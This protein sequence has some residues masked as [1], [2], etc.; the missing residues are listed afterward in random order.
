MLG[1]TLNNLGE[2]LGEGAPE[3]ERAAMTK[4][5]QGKIGG[6]PFLPH[7]NIKI[8]TTD[9][10]RYVNVTRYVPG[11]DIFDL[12]SGTIPLVPQPLQMNFGIAG[13]V[14]FLC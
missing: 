2:I 3:A 8:P 5:V 7:K 11:G 9:K 6:L 10:A 13:E 1:Y 12:N 4:E 14:L